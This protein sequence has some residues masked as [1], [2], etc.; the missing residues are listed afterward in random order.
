MRASLVIALALLAGCAE[1]TAN[2]A[3]PA[4]RDWNQARYDVGTLQ[5]S[6]SRSSMPYNELI[7]T[8]D[9]VLSRVRAAAYKICAETW[10]VVQGCEL[11]RV[12][13]VHVFRDDHTVNAFA[14]RNNRIGI[15]A[16][17]IRATGSDGELAA[18]VAHEFAHVMYGH[19]LQSGHNAALGQI[20][21]AF[22]GG[23][24]GARLGANPQQMG[25]AFSQAGAHIGG[26]VY[27]REMEIE[28]DHMAIYILH[29]AGFPPTA[30]RDVLVRLSRLS[31]TAGG[32]LATHPADDRR[33]AHAHDAIM[34]AKRDVPV[35]W[36]Q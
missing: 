31:P 30:M 23:A 16:G 9:R 14:D 12:A 2:V 36:R 32:F 20:F 5:L 26:R 8:V 28:A 21:G 35:T 18:V 25:D 13:P 34:R 29:R 6:P 17:M 33:L 3:A 7:P 19:G 15:Y 24:V 27:S 4:Q 10:G 11:M 22:L 1:P